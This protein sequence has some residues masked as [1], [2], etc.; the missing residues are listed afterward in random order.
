[1][2]TTDQKE[3]IFLKNQIYKYIS[4][5]HGFILLEKQMGWEHKSS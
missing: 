1:M 5:P 3:N 2:M 4:L